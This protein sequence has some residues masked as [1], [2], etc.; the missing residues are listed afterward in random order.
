MLP[1]SSCVTKC[2]MGPFSRDKAGDNPWVQSTSSRSCGPQ[3]Q[4]KTPHV[5]EVLRPVPIVVICCVPWGQEWCLV[6]C[7]TLFLLHFKKEI[8]AYKEFSPCPCRVST[9]VMSEAFWGAS[10][11]P[12]CWHWYPS[13]LL[14]P[15]PPGS[16]TWLNVN[17]VFYSLEQSLPDPKNISGPGSA[18]SHL[19]QCW[20]PSLT[21]QCL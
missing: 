6:T 17:L 18:S 8:L 15:E 1:T 14:I 7:V 16:L 20:M 11:L 13:G 9:C 4:L 2:Q 12:L 10:N 19:D 21:Q 3:P 5:G